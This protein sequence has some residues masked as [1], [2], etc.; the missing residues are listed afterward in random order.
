MGRVP[1]LHCRSMERDDFSEYEFSCVCTNIGISGP[2][3]QF[4]L[5]LMQ[6]LIEK[7]RVSCKFIHRTIQM[8]LAVMYMCICLS[9]HIPIIVLYDTRFFNNANLLSPTHPNLESQSKTLLCVGGR[10]CCG[11]I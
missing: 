4:G 11:P 2:R 1:L 10:V 6:I 3:M 7:D 9:R 5:G 8:Y